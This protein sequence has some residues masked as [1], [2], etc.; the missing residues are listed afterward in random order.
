MSKER[1]R[2]IK[3]AQSK[4]R[5]LNFVIDGTAGTPAASGFDRFQIK[6]VIDLGAGNYTVIFKSPFERACQL[7][8]WSTSTADVTMQVTAV[9]YDRITVQC[10]TAS[11]GAAVDADITL[12]VKGSDA[13]FDY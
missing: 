3:T 10:T 8:G 13:R 5:E 2:S 1:I 7:G 6:E 12:C 4:M 11:S 9:A